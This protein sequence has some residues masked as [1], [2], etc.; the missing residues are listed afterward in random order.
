MDKSKV[1]IADDEGRI[2]K[3][4]RDFLVKEGYDVYEAA[5]GMETIKYFQDII[6]L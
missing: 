4:V 5:D 1:L 2:R 3:L 6:H